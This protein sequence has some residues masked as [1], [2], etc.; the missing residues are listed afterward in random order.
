MGYNAKQK[1]SDNIAALQIALEQGDKPPFSKKELSALLKYSGFGGIKAVL[2]PYATREDW[3]EQGA[4]KADFRLYPLVIE[5]HELLEKHPQVPSY[6]KTIDSLKN[7]VLTAF[8]TPE[9]VPQTLYKALQE[10]GVTPKRIYEPS[11]GAGI[12]IT[13]AIKAFPELEHVTVVEK[14]FLTGKV[15]EAIS[16][17]WE[18]PSD[19]HISG[20]EETSLDDNGRY[21]LIVSNIP[22]G[23]FS[24]Y[25]KYFPDSVR[26]GKIHNY[27]FAKG[28][29]KIAD[30]GLLAY[31]TTDAFLNNPSNRPAREYLFA[32]ADFVS[33]SAMPDNLM[34]ETG[35]TQAP[36]HLLI[37]QK[38]TG[39]TGLSQ[40]EELLLETRELANEYG[41]YHSNRYLLQHPEI[42]IG[43]R[44]TPGKTNTARLIKPSGRK[45]ISKRSGNP[46][47]KTFPGI[48]GHA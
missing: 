5:L 38:N 22:F 15:L 3:E 17:S 36:S 40:E 33:L 47:L 41:I 6:R 21:D 7:S 19:V 9:T 16:S 39:K 8:Y 29:D 25:D 2:Y 12:F 26:S 34:Q 28:L 31:I 32:H 43:N 20:L 30:G 1:L 24:V 18:V 27:F 45:G 44:I 46:C 23:N 42:R 4:T 11:A 10:Q 14:D 37:V 48:S 35:N 13:E